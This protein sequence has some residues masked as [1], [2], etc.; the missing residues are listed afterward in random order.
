MVKAKGL[1]KVE[2]AWLSHGF[3]PRLLNRMIKLVQNSLLHKD[4]K[5]V[6]IQFNQLGA[7]QLVEDMAYLTKQ[8][9]NLELD[10]PKVAGIE[11]F[12]HLGKYLATNE[13]KS[14]HLPDAPQ[15]HRLRHGRSS[16]R[17]LRLQKLV[18]HSSL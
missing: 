17:T 3:V 16:R 15:L 2:E 10:L 6:H 5:K 14:K 4:S 8:L 12:V 7:N 1:L 13:R 11:R 9:N 18:S